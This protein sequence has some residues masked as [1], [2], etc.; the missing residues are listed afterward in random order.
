MK[1]DLPII[2][3]AGFFDSKNRFKGINVTAPRKVNTYELEF[4]FEDSGTAVINSK[5]YT[6]QKNHILFAKPGV[7][8]YSHLP[9]KCFFIHFTVADKTIINALD[10]ISE[11]FRISDANT[12]EQLFKNIIKNFYSANAFDNVT[13][14]A[15]LI[16]I[17]NYFCKT[18]IEK[19]NIISIAKRV[20]S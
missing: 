13:A 10:N 18:K 2:L 16:S 15:E 20:F 12:T 11:F 4:F 6:I 3:G 5:E 1:H 7:I 14:C 17:F 9:F 19:D 8:R